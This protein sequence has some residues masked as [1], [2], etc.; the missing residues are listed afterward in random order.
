MNVLIVGASGFVGSYL[1]NYLEK[2]GFKIFKG[3]RISRSS[4]ERSY[5]NFEDFSKKDDW[6]DLFK[7]VDAVVHCAARVHVM[8]ETSPDPLEE[9]RKSNVEATKILAEE[10]VRA[11]V[12]H[13]VFLSSIK[14][15]GE[16][17]FEKPFTEDDSPN[18]VD[19]YGISK[20]EAENVL[21]K[22]SQSSKMKVTVIRPPLIYGPGVKGNILKLKNLVNNFSIIP[23]GGVNNKRS[24]VSL[25]NLSSLIK[26]A[27]T[28]VDN[29][30][31]NVFLVSDQN[32]VS[33][34]ELVKSLGHSV[35]KNVV[36]VPVP[37]S[38]ISLILNLVG[39]RNLTGR[40]FGNLQVNSTKA[41]QSLDWEPSRDFIKNLNN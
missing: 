21:K 20:L 17:T 16:E 22:I 30:P 12:K 41:C 19:P 25:L 10:A 15:N 18:P 36:L 5:G 39:K 4:E 11:G 24:M 29:L 33:T 32:D 40:L 6:P 8:N 28:S 27:L 37:V 35:G 38:F 14:V 1:A 31:F 13:F 23:L 26:S 9:F 7:D 34:S 2:N 3:L